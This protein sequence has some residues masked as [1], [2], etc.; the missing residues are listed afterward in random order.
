MPLISLTGLTPGDFIYIRVWEYGGNEFGDFGICVTSPTPPP[1]PILPPNDECAD[2]IVA[3]VNPDALCTNTVS[4]SIAGATASA[5]ANACFGT[6]DDDVWYSFTATSTEHTLSL[7]NVAGSTTD[8]YHSV[9]AGTC[10]SIGAPILCSDPESSTL[11]GLT[12][13]NTYYIR[14]YSW[15][16]LS[17]QTSTFDLCIGTPPPP[18]TNITCGLMAPICSGSPIAFTAASGGGSAEPGNDYD[19]LFTQPN[20]SWYYLEISNPGDLIIDI[21][22]GSDVDYALWGPYVD[23]A[24]AQA[25]C[26]SHGLPVDCSY[27]AS[28]IEQA[29]VSGVVAGEVYVLLVTNYADIVQT[30]FVN[31]AAANTAATDCSIVPLPVELVTFTVDKT[32]VSNVLNWSTATERENHYFSIQRS[33]D[34]FVWETIGFVEGN[35]TTNQ[36][37]YY[38]YD[39]ENIVNGITYYRLK[40]VDYDGQFSYSM[41]RSVSRLSEQEK[42]TVYPMPNSGA[43]SVSS[44][45]EIKRMNITD[46]AGR[47]IEFS[48]QVITDLH[49]SVNLSSVSSGM[50][51]LE[52]VYVD[53]RTEALK[54]IVE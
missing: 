20:P 43:F 42:T 44:S 16:S 30:I 22:A 35:G 34:G 54:F 3:P 6:A 8:L 10:G 45:Q 31:E 15:T 14:I 48:A 21:T 53:D 41:I 13:G 37:S 27:S 39:D 25:T 52:I 18:P 26:G 33:D 46:L 49:Y 7:L 1:P 17:G 5:Q 36:T 47:T 50:Y 29:V 38:S 4:G 12:I 32:A 2:A 23:L 51:N 19:C 40:Q 24:E 28:P 9:Y 11:T